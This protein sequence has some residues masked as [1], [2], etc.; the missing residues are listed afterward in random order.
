MFGFEPVIITSRRL[1]L[2]GSLSSTRIPW[3][4]RS[5]S[6][7][8]FAIAPSEFRQDVTSDGAGLYRNSSKNRSDELRRQPR[9]RRVG[10]ELLGGALVEVHR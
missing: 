1:E 5:A 7:R 6:W 2:S 4:V 9:L 3:S 8:T 10:D